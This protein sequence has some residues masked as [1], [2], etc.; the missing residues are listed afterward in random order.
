[1]RAERVHQRGLVHDL[2]P[3]DV[4]KDRAGLHLPELSWPDHVPR[5]RCERNVD[6]DD[7]R[8]GQQ[9]VEFLR[10]AQDLNAEPGGLVGCWPCR[11]YPDDVQAQWQGQSPEFAARSVPACGRQAHH[12]RSGRK[13][14]PAGLAG[15]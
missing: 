3:G 15:F 9:V 2:A 8:R 13:P 6:G 11:V 12:R 14:R 1:M 10:S 7:V 4:D 5:V